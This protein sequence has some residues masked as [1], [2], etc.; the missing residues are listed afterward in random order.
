MKRYKEGSITVFL[1]L[2][3]L[4]VLAIILTTVETARVNAASALSLRA[5]ITGLDSV[6][7]EYY[8][9]LYKEYH[10][11]GLDAGYGLS[12]INQDKISEKLNS[13]ME[14]TFTPNKDLTE[15]SINNAYMQ[16]YGVQNTLR[17]DSIYSIQNIYGVGVKDIKTEK[18]TSLLEYDGELFE[19]QAMEYMK[20][21]VPADTLSSFFDN[22]KVLSD[23]K[24]SVEV[25]EEKEKT[26]AQVQKLDEIILQ[27][28]EKIDG[29][30]ISSKGIKL[31]S[32]QIAVKEFFIKKIQNNPISM[33]H[34][35]INNDWVFGSLKSHYRNL[36]NEM[37][38]VLKRIDVLKII[39]EKIYSMQN[40]IVALSQI[41]TVNMLKEEKE[42]FDERIRDANNR[43]DSL[44]KE[45]H[46]LIISINSDVKS[47]KEQVAG[48][49]K[50]TKEAMEILNNGQSFQNDVTKKI[51]DYEKLVKSNQDKM[52]EEFYNGLKEGV[53]ILSKYKGTKTG[54]EFDN[55]AEE[56]YDFA[57]MKQNLAENERILNNA[58]NT[59]SISLNASD[60]ESVIVYENSLNSFQEAMNQYNTLNIK[61]DYSTLTRP[62]DSESFLNGIKDLIKNGILYLVIDDSDIISE[63]VMDIE[64]LPSDLLEKDFQI[65]ADT[66]ELLK[67]IDL[68]NGSELLNNLLSKNAFQS[69]TDFGEKELNLILYQEYLYEHFEYFREEKIFKHNVLDYELEYILNGNSDDKD[70]L[71][72][73]IMQ[74]L[75]VRTILNLITLLSDGT[76]V[77]EAKLLAAS[78]VGFTGMPL[79]LEAVK[80]VILTFWALAEA[81]I[82]I[83]ALVKD[84]AVPV[85]KTGKEMQISLL[86][87]MGINKALIHKKALNYKEM[88]TPLTLKYKDYIGLFLFFE[89]KEKKIYRTMDLI[90]ENL[91]LKYEDS[92]YMKNC[93]TGVNI[94]AIFHMNS[95]FVNIPFVHTFLNK[96]TDGYQYQFSW[97]YTY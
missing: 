63:K 26:E 91:R 30:T 43:L 2:I 28:M 19:K 83:T 20:Y 13:Y 61:F 18:L 9:P 17:A 47:I 88:K 15:D 40:E 84:R 75:T 48:V 97:E 10:I 77:S 21:K 72:S 45:R 7:A 55:K 37:S 66:K 5:L 24:T 64:D 94:T 35:G 42:I 4:L 71:S 95:K 54:E 36:N 96:D 81:L 14:Y 34:A 1:S 79:L 68:D 6:M 53:E 82:D 85:F 11:F 80:M 49:L 56:V 25:L 12:E 87:I 58:L 23:A 86:E 67:S 22:A 78:F 29:I 76:K 8:A 93:L 69:V 39:N 52:G 44:I 62:E 59:I 16:M 41:D 27:L 31:R 51:E 89:N 92:F 60:D 38:D 33:Y 3:L 46:T 57:A 74:I 90:Q 32:G 70:N 65:L 73:A 50:V